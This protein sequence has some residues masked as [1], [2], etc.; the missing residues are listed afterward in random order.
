MLIQKERS[1]I[2]TGC[3]VMEGMSTVEI[4][5]GGIYL[6]LPVS[7]ETVSTGGTSVPLGLE[8]VERTESTSS[9]LSFFVVLVYDDKLIKDETPFL[10]ILLLVLPDSVR[11]TSSSPNGTDV[12][13]VLTVSVET[14]RER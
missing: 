1:S 14:G 9:F 4:D 10:N 12:P 5:V 7:T 3:L 13:P 8:D 11:S 6:S 2:G